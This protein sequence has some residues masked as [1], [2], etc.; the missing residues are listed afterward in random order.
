[1][2]TSRQG[3][4]VMRRLCGPLLMSTGALD[5]L[6]VLVFHSRQLA[7]I[8]QDGFSDAVEPDVA[9]ST[10]DRETAF[11][12]MM[13]GLMVLI[14]GGLIYWAQARTGPLPVFLGW[15]LLTI[16]VAA[17]VLPQAVMMI[18]AARRG[19]SRTG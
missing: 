19:R 2:E 11:W 9:F 14:L 7:A 16:S 5:V 6:Y 10:F 18:V 13:F 17:L 4:I 1:M 3:R 8:A 12:H 15:S